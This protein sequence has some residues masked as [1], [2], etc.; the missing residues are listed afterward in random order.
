M[1]R[2]HSEPDNRR[3]AFPDYETYSSGRQIDA[4]LAASTDASSTKVASMVQIRLTA[5]CLRGAPNQMG[6]RALRRQRHKV[7]GIQGMHNS[8]AS[9]MTCS[10]SLGPVATVITLSQG[11]KTS[12]YP[13]KPYAPR[14][15]R[16]IKL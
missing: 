4:C 8:R 11:H 9:Y 5:V 3:V 14:L 1:K 7:T 10:V 15:G 13:L 6:S 2:Y 12:E 16:Y